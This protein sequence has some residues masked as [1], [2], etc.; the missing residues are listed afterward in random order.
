MAI[1]TSSPS[2]STGASRTAGDRVIWLRSTRLPYAARSEF[3]DGISEYVKIGRMGL[4]VPKGQ[5]YL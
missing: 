4:I 5:E 2:G 3:A 1:W